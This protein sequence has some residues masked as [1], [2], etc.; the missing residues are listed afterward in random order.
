MSSNK[1]RLTESQKVEI[2]RLYLEVGMN[3]VAIAMRLGLTHTQQIYNYLHASKIYLKFRNGNGIRRKYTLDETFFDVI[4]TE[5][6]AYVLGFIAADGYVDDTNNRIVI[7]LNVKDEDILAKI[8]D[9]VN[10]NQK[11]KYFIK[12]GKYNHCKISLNS[13]KIVSSIIKRGVLPR[14]SLT[15]SGEVIDSI[16]KE[17][18]RHFL[19]GYFEGDGHVTYGSKYA[20]GIKYCVVIIGTLDFLTK[21]FKANCISN[22]LIKK[23]SS[24]GMYR[25]VT[26]KRDHVDAFLTYIYKDSTIYLNRKYA[27]YCAHVKPRELLETLACNEEGNQQPSPIREGSETIEKQLS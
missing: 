10:S 15:M 25:W 19:R 8:L 13:K 6:K 26:S 2:Q 1:N 5:A 22:S 12:D 9:K 3:P 11:I 24:C 20:S 7:S 14:K 27:I 17:F 23:Y 4:D 18:V 16:P 21:T